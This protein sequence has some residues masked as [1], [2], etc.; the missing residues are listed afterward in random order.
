MSFGQDRVVAALYLKGK[1][2][3]Y[4]LMKGNHNRL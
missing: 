2:T 3:T 1:N 4:G